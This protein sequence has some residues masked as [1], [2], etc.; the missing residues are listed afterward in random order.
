MNEQN[1]NEHSLIERQEK[2]NKTRQN[3]KTR[4]RKTDIAVYP[5]I[6]LL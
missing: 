1:E 2:G 5:K 6:D 3:S 4:K